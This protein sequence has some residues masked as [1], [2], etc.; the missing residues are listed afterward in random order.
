MEKNASEDWVAL[1]DFLDRLLG[2]RAH[3][4]HTSWLDWVQA[5]KA[6]NESDDTFLQRFNTLKTQIGDEANDLAKTEVMLFF[7]RLDKPMQQIIRK[8]SSIPETKHDGCSCE[9]TPTQP[10]L[11]GQT[12][13]ANTYS[14]Y[15]FYF[16][17]TWAKWCSCRQLFA[18]GKP[19]ERGLLLLL[20]KKKPQIG[21]MWEQIWQY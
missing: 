21:A 9:E 18:R 17:L 4:V 5:K 7:G 1:K 16:C 11:W 19:Q 8:Q 20:W 2:D 14:S 6:S 10:R 13:L 15:T 12:I 3:R